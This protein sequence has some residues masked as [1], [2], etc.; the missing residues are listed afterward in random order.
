MTLKF[1]NEE[2]QCEIKILNIT[3]LDVVGIVI[4]LQIE[5]LENI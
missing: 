1:F 5:I 3:N 4:N 2:Y